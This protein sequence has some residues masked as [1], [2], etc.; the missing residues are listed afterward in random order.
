MLDPKVDIAYIFSF[1]LIADTPMLRLN[2]TKLYHANL[3]NATVLTFSIIMSI[4]S[5]ESTRPLSFW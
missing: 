2:F 1:Q 4:T 5:K 3:R